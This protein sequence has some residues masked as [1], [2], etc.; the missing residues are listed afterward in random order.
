MCVCVSEWMN[1]YIHTH[2]L[3]C[4][5]NCVEEN[6]CF[7]KR[8]DAMIRKKPCFVFS[9]SC[10]LFP[11]SK[12]DDWN[13]PWIY[14]LSVRNCEVHTMNR[15]QLHRSRPS[16]ADTHRSCITYT[17]YNASLSKLWNKQPIHHLLLI[18]DP[19]SAS[20]L[21]ATDTSLRQLNSLCIPTLLLTVLVFHYLQIPSINFNS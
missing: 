15:P 9:I 18:G 5:Y 3:F 6:L 16:L 7:S 14:G 13:I 17:V 4:V 2:I 12:E 21:L 20:G 1:E 11:N 8:C 19:T 10:A